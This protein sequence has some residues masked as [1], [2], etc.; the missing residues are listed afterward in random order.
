MVRPRAFAVLRLTT[1][2]EAGATLGQL[3]PAQCAR[4]GKVWTVRH[5]RLPP[6]RFYAGCET[7][8]GAVPM[9]RATTRPEA[10]VRTATRWIA[11]SRPTRSATR[12]DR[13]APTA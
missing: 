3:G 10:R 5:V 11:A 4:D 1:R 8:T 13:R 7:G 6:A 12:P 2:E 9:R